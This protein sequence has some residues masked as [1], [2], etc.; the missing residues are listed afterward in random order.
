MQ[1]VAMEHLYVLWDRMLRELEIEWPDQAPIMPQ[2]P[3]TTLVVVVG[4]N[5][6]LGLAGV[7]DQIV[8]QLLRQ[9]AGTVRLSCGKCCAQILASGG[10]FLA[11]LCCNGYHPLALLC[12]NHPNEVSNHPEISECGKR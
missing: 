10:F 1:G 3:G 12:C 2:L 8:T 7:G 11:L 4:G 6:G 5:Y 9:V